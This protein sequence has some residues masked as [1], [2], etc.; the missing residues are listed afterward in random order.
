VKWCI[1]KVEISL[2]SLLCM[3]LLKRKH[4]QAFLNELHT[5][6]LD[7]KNPII[8]G[9]DFNLVRY[10]VDKSNRRVD[11][12]WCDKFNEWI[13]KHYLV[14]INLSGRGYTWS[15]NQQNQILSYIDRVFYSTE[16]DCLF[17]FGDSQGF[18][19]GPK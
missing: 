5:S 4:K 18:A 12:K 16:F 9:G 14:E 10:L 7:D 8:I 13:D 15:N 6:M 3:V 11:F 19:Q 1:R 17:S 2:E